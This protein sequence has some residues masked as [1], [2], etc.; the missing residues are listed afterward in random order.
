MSLSSPTTT[1]ASLEHRHCFRPHYHHPIS[2]PH[3]WHPAAIG[4][5]SRET[6]MIHSQPYRSAAEYFR[7]VAVPRE[8]IAPMIYYCT[9]CSPDARRE[10]H[11][12]GSDGR[13]ECVLPRHSVSAVPPILEAGTVPLVPLSPV[14]SSCGPLWARG[15]L[16]YRMSART[17]SMRSHSSHFG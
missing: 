2:R 1:I 10:S 11:Q 16:H 14:G 13:A 4:R 5:L 9:P 17:C 8:L 6:A 7:L 15:K 12:T 3:Q